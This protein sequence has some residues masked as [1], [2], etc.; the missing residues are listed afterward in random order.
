M[1][2]KLKNLHKLRPISRNQSQNN[3]NKQIMSIQAFLKLRKPDSLL[4]CYNLSFKERIYVSGSGSTS[5]S[6]IVWPLDQTRFVSLS[7]AFIDIRTSILN[8]TGFKVRWLL[9]QREFAFRNNQE[10]INWLD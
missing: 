6:P 10:R 2:S 8:K 5:D 3:S 7:D 4:G 1:V 9:E